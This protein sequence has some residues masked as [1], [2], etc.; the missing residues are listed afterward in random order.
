MSSQ[1]EA[2]WLPPN[3]ATVSDSIEEFNCQNRGG[4]GVRS[5]EI[6][7]K[8]GDLIGAKLVDNK[9]GNYA[10]NQRGH[11]IKMLVN[12]INWKKYTLA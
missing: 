6:I 8:T 5:Y 12:D 2:C 7:D 9:Q 11:I 3:T 1:G 10:D 4:K